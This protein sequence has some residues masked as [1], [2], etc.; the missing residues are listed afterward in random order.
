M[1]IQPSP[2]TAAQGKRYF[3]GGVFFA[4]IAALFLFVA[5]VSLSFFCV[6]CFRLAF[7]D[8][9]P[10][11]RTVGLEPRMSI[12]PAKTMHRPQRLCGLKNHSPIRAD[13][14]SPGFWKQRRA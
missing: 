8:L 12:V 5:A 10:M 6:A 9:S 11:S 1:A 13:T 7:G 4:A 2:L 3:F 14:R